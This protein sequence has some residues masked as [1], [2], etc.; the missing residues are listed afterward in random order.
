MKR[1]RG[2]KPG[3]LVKYSPTFL[4]VSDDLKDRIYIIV[5]KDDKYLYCEVLDN[6]TGFIDKFWTEDLEKL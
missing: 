2:P 1:R 4:K 5:R 6:H 3:D